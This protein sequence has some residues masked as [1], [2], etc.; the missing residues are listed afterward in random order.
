M[1]P[2]PGLKRELL[3]GQCQRQQKPAQHF[4]QPHAVSPGHKI[5]RLRRNMKRCIDFSFCFFSFFPSSLSLWT[6]QTSTG[7]ASLAPQWVMLESFCFFVPPQFDPNP[8]LLFEGP[9]FGV[10][11]T[12]VPQMSPQVLAEG[13]SPDLSLCWGASENTLAPS[14]PAPARSLPDDPRAKLSRLL[15]VSALARPQEP[16]DLPAGTG[17]ATSDILLPKNT[18]ILGLVCSV[19]CHPHVGCHPVGAAVGWGRGFASWLCFQRSP[20]CWGQPGLRLCWGL[21]A[22]PC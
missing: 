8:P 21:G 17:G 3:Q 2:C 7:G 10:T 6:P 14:P 1:P 4:P 5:K 13:D 11:H 16:C 18:G 12:A 20:G 9:K 22:S 15:R 19:G